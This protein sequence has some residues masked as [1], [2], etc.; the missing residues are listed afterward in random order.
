M[1]GMS[2]RSRI[3]MFFVPAFT[4]ALLLAPDAGLTGPYEVSGIEVQASA[5]D[6][7]QAK[8]KAIAEGQQQAIRTMLERITNSAD[9]GRLPVPS[10]AEIE[11]MISGFGVDEE[12]TSATTYGA[13]LTYHFERQ[14]VRDV[15]LRAGIPFND[16]E[17]PPSLLIPIYQE[18]ESF[19]LW[20]NNPHLEAWRALE[21]G[22]R[23]TPV[24]LPDGDISDADVDPNAVLARDVD[25]FSGL[26]LRY[27][28]NNVLVALCRTD[29][30]R[31]RYDCTLEGGG[32]SGPVSTQQ[33]YTGEPQ[34]SMMAAA[35]AFLDYLEDQWK[36][37]NMAGMPGLRT[38]EP[39]EASVAFSGLREWQL[40]RS[41]LLGLA[42]VSEVEVRALNPRG[43]L[44]VLHVSG[45]PVEL[46][47]A[48]APLGLELADTGG[49]WVI[50]PY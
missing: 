21:P 49:M 11:T 38:G 33:S 44:L 34:A 12:R 10:P 24:I 37:N 42:E 27:K 13:R 35:A 48:L 16:Q 30:N 25:T 14:P 18:G 22:N 29:L 4:A 23:L 43:A 2:V 8:K 26:R 7:V 3:W 5:D 50:R 31:S 19:Y 47:N 46:S 17:A 15:L 39:V 9:H 45:G 36:A 40:L 20:E 32:P 1:A 41:K 6:A 28:V